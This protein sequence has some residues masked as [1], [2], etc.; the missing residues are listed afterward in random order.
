M[1]QTLCQLKKK[2]GSG[3]AGANFPSDTLLEFGYRGTATHAVTGGTTGNISN[4]GS[5]PREFIFNSKSYSSVRLRSNNYVSGAFTVIKGNEI[6]KNESFNGTSDVSKDIS[7]GDFCIF[8][9]L[10]ST[11]VSYLNFT[12]T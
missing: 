1:A 8:T 11:S 9:M 4:S 12:F 7:G 6:I 3:G 2:G 5:S 10:N